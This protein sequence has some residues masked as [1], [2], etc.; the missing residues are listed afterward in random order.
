[1]HTPHSREEGITADI[2]I[3]TLDD[4]PQSSHQAPSRNNV[5]DLETGNRSMVSPGAEQLARSRAEETE[6]HRPTEDAEGT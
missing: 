4:E 1:M 3:T 2:Y 5:E 6:N